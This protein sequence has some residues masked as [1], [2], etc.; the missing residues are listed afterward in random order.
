MSYIHSGTFFIDEIM[1]KE[2]QSMIVCF[3]TF[4]GD[5]TVCE[6]GTNLKDL[7]CHLHDA[8]FATLSS[9]SRDFKCLVSACLRSVDWEWHLVHNALGIMHCWCRPVGI[10]HYGKKD[11]F[12]MRARWL[13]GQ[14]EPDASGAQL[15]NAQFLPNRNG[16]H[17]HQVPIWDL[18]YVCFNRIW[19]RVESPFSFSPGRKLNN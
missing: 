10:I 9:T 17:I 13:T 7:R 3:I 16:E 2:R 15:E 1:W 5:L 18:R 4:I 11:T 12:R 14:S 6:K 8:F 19:R